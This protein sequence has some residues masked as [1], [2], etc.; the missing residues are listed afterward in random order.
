MNY[1]VFLFSNGSMLK[2]SNGLLL[3]L[4]VSEMQWLAPFWLQP[5]LSVMHQSGARSSSA[6]VEQ[7]GKLC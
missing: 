6:L 1:R 5:V 2:G 7:M 3:G 4:P